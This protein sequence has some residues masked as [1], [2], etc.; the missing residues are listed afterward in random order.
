MTGQVSGP[1][2][3]PLVTDSPFNLNTFSH[4]VRAVGNRPQLLPYAKKYLV[5]QHGQC[6]CHSVPYITAAD[7]ISAQINRAWGNR[8]FLAQ[9]QEALIPFVD[10]LLPEAF[11]AKYPGQEQEL[12]RQQDHCRAV[13]EGLPLEFLSP[14]PN[15]RYVW[16][17]AIALAGRLFSA[18]SN[19]RL[20]DTRWAAIVQDHFDPTAWFYWEAGSLRFAHNLKAPYS[21]NSGV[22]PPAGLPIPLSD[23]FY[24]HDCKDCWQL[25]LAG[26]ADLLVPTRAIRYCDADATPTL[27][28]SSNVAV[29]CVGLAVL[30]GC[31]RHYLHPITRC[32]VAF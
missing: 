1:L 10:I 7:E 15:A 26:E 24:L 19:L 23:G 32:W 21:S 8:C 18:L 29:P 31:L 16:N 11:F 5:G 20:G 25:M 13:A 12:V 28:G 30:T 4:L 9:L 2:L 14:G 6:V 17:D 22:A 27:A 3:Y